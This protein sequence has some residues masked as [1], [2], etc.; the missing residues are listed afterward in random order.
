[1]SNNGKKIKAETGRA[2]AD[3]INFWGDWDNA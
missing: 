2:I 3:L 1:M